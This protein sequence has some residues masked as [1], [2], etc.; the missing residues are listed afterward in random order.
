M[1]EKV[2]LELPEDL[3]HQAR[4][5]AARTQRSFDEVLV[6]WI[7]QAGSEPVLELLPDEELL[8]VCDSQPSSQI[9]GFLPPLFAHLCLLFS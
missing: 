5:V 4:M 8:A 7:P 1:A 6:D 3:A 2:T 9:Q